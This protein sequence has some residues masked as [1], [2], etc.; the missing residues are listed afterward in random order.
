MIRSYAKS[1]CLLHVSVV[2][3]VK[4]SGRRLRYGGI[5]SDGSPLKD[6][7]GNVVY[8][9]EGRAPEVRADF[10]GTGFIAGEGKILTNHHV[11][12]PWW[13]NEELAGASKQ[14]LEPVIAE[15]TAYFPGAPNGIGVNIS[16]ISSEADLPWFTG[17]SRSFKR[18]ALKLTASGGRR[19]RGSTDQRRVRHR[20]RRDPGAR[21]R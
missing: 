10:F 11:V 18:P 2:F 3:N 7:D 13:Q 21:R 12:Q 16:Q 5:A 14:G 1:V 9:T 8:T 19:Q 20:A 15:M 17:T 4:E 6:S